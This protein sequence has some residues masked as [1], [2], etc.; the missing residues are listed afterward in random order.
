MIN[1]S[2]LLQERRNDI[3]YSVSGLVPME[4]KKED[5]T[6]IDAVFLDAS[7]TGVGMIVE[8]TLKVD[9]QMMLK[10]SGS[11]ELQVSVR[12]IKKP[13]GFNSSNGPSFHRAGL[14]LIMDE[15]NPKL[16]LLEILENFNCVDH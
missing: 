8:P 14:S 6:S 13:V 1:E 4:L 15:N 9:Q 3:R 10:L 2:T 11:Y 16:N 5:G 7:R 12:W